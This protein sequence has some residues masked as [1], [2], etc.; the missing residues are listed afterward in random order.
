[1]PDRPWLRVGTSK[2]NGLWLVHRA[3]WEAIGWQLKREYEPPKELTPRLAVLVAAID[4]LE[5]VA[6]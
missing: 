5:D 6:D 3:M 4:K 2:T 1:M